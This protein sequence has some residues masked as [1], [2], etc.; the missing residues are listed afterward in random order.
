V[1]VGQHEGKVFIDLGNPGWAAVK[2]T[3]AGWSINRNPPLKFLRSSSM[4]SL[5][6]PERGGMIEELRGFLNVQSD[7]D[8]MLTIA[9]LV[10]ALNA[11]GPYP[12]LVLNG[13]QGTGKSVFSRMIRS[14]VDPSAA[15]IRSVPKDDRDLVVSASNSLVL[16]FDNLSGVP[17]WFSDALSRLATQSGFATRMLHTN[18]SFSRALGQSS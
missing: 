12:V 3:A 13:E 7:G 6:E 11:R 14:L 9:W 4:R 16:A 17:G 15:S 8:F 10:A 18:N 1:S 2:V 5:P